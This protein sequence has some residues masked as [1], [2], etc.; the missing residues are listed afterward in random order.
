[1][2]FF[3]NWIIFYFGKETYVSHHNFSQQ[4]LKKGYL[5]FPAPGPLLCISL[6]PNLYLPALAPNL[7]SPALAPN[8]YLTALAPNMC[9]PALAP[10]LCLA[11]SWSW[12]LICYLPVQVKILLLLTAAT[13][14]ITTTTITTTTTTTT[15]TSTTGDN[16]KRYLHGSN[17]H[18]NGP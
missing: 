15:T 9:L 5:Y 17:I 11:A 6:A 1:M 7:Y 13:C 12:P 18:I 16:N 14:T 8:L 2:V 4:L 10:N 3:Y